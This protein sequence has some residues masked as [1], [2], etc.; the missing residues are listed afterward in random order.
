M[1]RPQH[2]SDDTIIEALAAAGEVT[3]AELA[4]APRHRP[5]HRGQA[6]GRPR[7]RPGRSGA[8]RAAG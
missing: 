8:S 5:V 1:A 6:P 4:D 2:I 7:R 3:A